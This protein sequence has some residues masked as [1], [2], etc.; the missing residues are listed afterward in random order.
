MKVAYPSVA[1]M[2]KQEEE[3]S[4]NDGQVRG[5]DDRVIYRREK[6]LG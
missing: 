1:M 2:D 4:G 6:D 3:M 5:R